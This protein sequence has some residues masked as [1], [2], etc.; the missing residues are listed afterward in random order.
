MD[1]KK[2]SPSTQWWR[3]AEQSFCKCYNA[4]IGGAKTKIKP[5]FCLNKETPRS[6]FFRKC[7]KKRHI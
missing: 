7:K 1:N 4:N 5:Q 6:K 2:N 3:T